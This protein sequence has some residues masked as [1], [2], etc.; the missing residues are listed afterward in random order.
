VLTKERW[1]AFSEEEKQA[2]RNSIFSAADENG[3]WPSA[4]EED[5]G[6]YLD[7][8]VS[9]Y[10]VTGFPFPVLNDNDKYTIMAKLLRFSSN[11]AQF[12]FK[13][14]TEYAN[15]LIANNAVLQDG[16]GLNLANSY[17]PHM[18]SIKCGKKWTPM[19][20][21]AQDKMLRRIISKAM[22]LQNHVSDS[23]LR[24]MVKIFTNTQMVSNFRPTAAASIY[25]N[26]LPEA[27]GVVWDMSSGFGGRL[28]GAI[29]CHRVKH[30]IGTD[31][32]SPTMKG[33]MRMK[34]ELVPLAT[35][36]GRAPL[37]VTL[38][39]IGSEDYSFVKA[40]S[41]DLC[42][43]SPPYFDT[44]KYSDEKTQSFFKYPTQDAWLYG[45]MRKTLANCHRGLKQDGYLVV[46]I[47][48]VRS[49]PNL[50]KEFVEMAEANRFKLVDTLQLNLSRMP[51]KNLA[52]TKYKL[53]PIF[54]FLKV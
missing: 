23:S 51:G 1:A 48:A 11:S 34:A 22:L 35:Q 15:P 24:G 18:W 12:D 3:N 39:K 46:N 19:E 52:K 37:S 16:H 26:F 30:Y 6:A 7:A 40:N 29:M 21:F 8:V 31:P 32:S 54:V 17:F 53:E 28:L 5:K 38:Y 44:E 10:R 4:I 33:L 27:G 9:Y 13:G 42:F 25:Y 45:F 14:G 50:A 41:L 47:A 20:V 49:Y 36:L 43:T 2:Y